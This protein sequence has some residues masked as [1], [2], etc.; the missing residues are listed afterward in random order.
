MPFYDFHCSA[1]DTQSEIFQTF[2]EFDNPN[3]KVQCQKCGCKSKRKISRK[4]TPRVNF[5]DRVTPTTF[6]AVGEKNAKKLGKEQ[7]QLMQEAKVERRQNML[8]KR[9]ETNGVNAKVN[10]IDKT[11]ETPFWREPGEK[12]L[13]LKT[14]KDVN[15]YIATGEKS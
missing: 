2:A 12:V 8:Q 9:L 4:F 7:L 5:I 15:K 13:D 6:G 11:P 1:C 10:K 3:T 14:I